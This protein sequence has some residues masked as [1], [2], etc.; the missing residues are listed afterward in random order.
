MQPHVLVF[1]EVR[2]AHARVKALRNR[3]TRITT[4]DR[5]TKDDLT[6]Y[7]R[8]IAV[9][10][11]APP[12]E[13]VE[14]ALALHRVDP[15]FAVG[16]FH[17]LTQDK[18]ARVAAALGL[19]FYP[20]EV[21]ENTRYKDTMRAALR[22]AG[23]DMTMNRRVTSAE[24]VAE[25]AAAYGY[26]VI[27]KP[28]DG[29]ASTGVSR[30]GAPE[31]IEP[32]VAWAR[33][34]APGAALCVEQFL[35]GE[36]WSVEAISENGAHHLICVTQKFKEG[37]HFVE[38]GHRVPA[39]LDQETHAAIYGL[40]ERALTALGITYGPSHTEVIVAADGPHIVETHARPGGDSIP[41]LVELTFG[42]DL[43][44]LWVRQ[45]LG[46]TVMPEV[47]AA[48]RQH[49]FAAIWFTT[50][51][52]TGVLQAVEG[53]D[54]AHAVPG[55]VEIEIQQ[56]VGATLSG[57]RDSWSRAACVIATGET[58]EQALDRAQEAAGQ[59]RF[60]LDTSAAGAG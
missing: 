57:L 10:V 30:I 49:P 25:F 26:P 42:F 31:E 43:I 54:D 18:A 8:I 47:E 59:L 58:P 9:P 1:G 53:Q 13:W 41:R 4:I 19:P 60:V 55:V 45:A 6:A 20:L 15:F 52:A 34:S 12:E 48:Q 11:S 2:I 32:A 27:L 7:E 21:I 14:L 22:A 3:V 5:I 24:E 56:P 33:A 36:E 44:D 23:V 28:V 16:G 29:W 38:L 50:P 17:E 51:S 37:Q 46:A 35:T 39:T 40:V